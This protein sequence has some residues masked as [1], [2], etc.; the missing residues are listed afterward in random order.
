MFFQC[1]Y[2]YRFDLNLC[3]FDLYFCLFGLYLCLLEFICIHLTCFCI[4]WTCICICA[5]ALDWMGANE[6]LK[7]A[8]ALCPIIPQLIKQSAGHKL[9]STFRS[10]FKTKTS[11]KN[12]QTHNFFLKSRGHFE[13]GMT[14]Q[15]WPLAYSYF[16]HRFCL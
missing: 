4:C 2:L 9:D 12:I 14:Y 10:K 11:S 16:W 5:I 3:L 7:R 15:N 6:G 1:I 13:S 8:F